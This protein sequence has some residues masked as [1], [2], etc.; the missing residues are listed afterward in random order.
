MMIL[1]LRLQHSKQ[2][3]LQRRD[4]LAGEAE[5]MS[6]QEKDALFSKLFPSY[7]DE[8]ADPELKSLEMGHTLSTESG[9]TLSR[10]QSQ[11]LL[12]LE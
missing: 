10:A 11:L 4:E 1:L 9:I 7:G 12:L 3:I 2:M 8:I 6:S 5:K